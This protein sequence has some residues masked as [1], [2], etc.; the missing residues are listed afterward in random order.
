[1]VSPDCNMDVREIFVLALCKDSSE[2]KNLQFVY[3]LTC[4]N[5]WPL[6]IRAA[7]LN[8]NSEIGMRSAV[9]TKLPKSLSTKLKIRIRKGNIITEDHYDSHP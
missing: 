3:N 4:G 2:K 5:Y 6:A 1:M 9:G 8:T 7:H